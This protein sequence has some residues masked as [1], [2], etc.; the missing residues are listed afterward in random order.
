MKNN[1][2]KQEDLRE[3]KHLSDSNTLLSLVLGLYLGLILKNIKMAEDN[4]FI[5]AIIA[6]ALS[7]I[8][9][10]RVKREYEL[11]ERIDNHKY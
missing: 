1:Q 3:F 9:Y 11:K 7:I 4:I 6:I 5:T 8:V 2:N 10:K